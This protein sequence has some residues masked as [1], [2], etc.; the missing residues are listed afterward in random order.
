MVRCVLIFTGQLM[1][2][3]VCFIHQFYL[4]QQIGFSSRSELLFVLYSC[5]PL[6]LPFD[7]V[8]ICLVPSASSQDYGS[9]TCSKM[10]SLSYI[11]LWNSKTWP[12]LSCSVQTCNN[13]HLPASQL[14]EE[15]LLSPDS[16]SNFKKT[17]IANLC[18]VMVEAGS[19]GT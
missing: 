12:S 16:P 7:S 2:M 6:F 5:T 4:L 18:M 10:W 9:N 13:N 15:R 3:G 19:L 1:N 8:T 17:K 11:A 14:W